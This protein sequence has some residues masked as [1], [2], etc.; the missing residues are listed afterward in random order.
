M[1]PHSCSFISKEALALVTA[2]SVSPIFM[3]S[4]TICKNL[5]TTTISAFLSIVLLEGSC[6][7]GWGIS[8]ALGGK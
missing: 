3:S 8:E 4:P 1:L 5:P 2:L 7:E 6:D